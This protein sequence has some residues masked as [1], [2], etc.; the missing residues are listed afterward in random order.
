MQRIILASRVVN[1]NTKSLM[2][3]V[4]T[5]LLSNAGIEKFTFNVYHHKSN[6]I[7][8]IQTKMRE[9]G[10]CVNWRINSGESPNFN[11]SCSVINPYIEKNR[12]QGK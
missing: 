2:N 4:N 10:W 1:S 6:E 8:K 9:S 7:V 11:W 3:N 5:V 12:L